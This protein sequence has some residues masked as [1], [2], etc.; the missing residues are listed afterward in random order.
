[1]NRR[2]VDAFYAL[3]PEYVNGS[4][5]DADTAKLEAALRRSPELKD[6]LA[7]ERLLHT[8]LKNGVDAMIDDAEQNSEKRLAALNE[9]TD[10]SGTAA[11]SKKSGLA[12]ALALL[13]PR[14]WHPAIAL[15]LALAIPAQAA[16]ISTQATTIASLEDENFQLASEPCAKEHGESNILLEFKQQASWVDVAAL[17]DQEELTIFRQGSFGTLNVRSKL[18]ADELGALIEKL[19][20]SPIVVSAAQAK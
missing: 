13:N 19:R 18:K 10:Q 1:M 7:Q 12:S 9:K 4:L 15:S 6:A 3:L 16:V 8:R 17:L 2:E 5:N 20:A 11:A 14:R